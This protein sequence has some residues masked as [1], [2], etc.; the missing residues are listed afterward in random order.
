M[1]TT[2]CFIECTECVNNYMFALIQWMYV[3]SENMSNTNVIKLGFF[4]MQNIL[5]LTPYENFC[6]NDKVMSFHGFQINQIKLVWNLVV[7]LFCLLVL[8]ICF[9]YW[10][11]LLVL[12]FV[13]FNCFVYLFCLFV[14]F[15]GLLPQCADKSATTCL[16]IGSDYPPRIIRSFPSRL[17]NSTFHIETRYRYKIQTNV[18]IYLDTQKDPPRLQLW[19]QKTT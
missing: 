19:A 11:Y 17:E 18:Q 6:Q 16:G 3:F 10:F 8:F 12:I 4:D 14:W 1:P 2:R 13:L 15:L 9:V 5:K 7:C